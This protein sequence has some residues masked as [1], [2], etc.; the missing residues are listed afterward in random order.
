MDDPNLFYRDMARWGIIRAL[1]RQEN[2]RKLRQFRV[3]QYELLGLAGS[4]MLIYL[5]TDTLLTVLMSMAAV[6]MSI[7]E[8]WR[9]RRTGRYWRTWVREPRNPEEIEYVERVYGSKS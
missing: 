1:Y 6:Q 5:L 8:C 4:M 3:R 9:M 7:K 2:R